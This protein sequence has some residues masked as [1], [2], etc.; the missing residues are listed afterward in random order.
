[1]EYFRRIGEGVELGNGAI[2]KITN[3]NKRHLNQHTM[4]LIPIPFVRKQQISTRGAQIYAYSGENSKL[5]R[6]SFPKSV[7]SQPKELFG[8]VVWQACTLSDRN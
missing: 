4:V 3:R 6:Q 2:F 1:M 8:A 7:Y 5:I